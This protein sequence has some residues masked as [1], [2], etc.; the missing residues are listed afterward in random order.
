MAAATAGQSVAELLVG[1]VLLME[2]EEKVPLTSLILSILGFTLILF[3]LAGLGAWLKDGGFI[4]RI[5]VRM[6]LLRQ[7]DS[8]VA[9]LP[10]RI[11]SIRNLLTARAKP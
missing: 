8:K 3:I 1:P 11:P 7:I 5:A 6:N 9:E 2:V 4:G 10:T